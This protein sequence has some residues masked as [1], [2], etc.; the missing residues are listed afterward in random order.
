V[1]VKLG[2]LNSG[3]WVV[4]NVV[5]I[6]D[7]PLK[8]EQLV[9]NTAQHD[10]VECT[11]G[12]EQDPGSA[13]VADVD[14]MVRKLAGFSIKVFKPTKDKITRAGPVSAQAEAGNIFIV[15]AAWN[16]A[17]LTSLENFPPEN[18][19]GH[20][21]DVDALSGAFNSLAQGYSILDVL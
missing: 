3:N 7:T 2:K 21:D 12:L 1:G 14:N 10:G 6:R 17:F 20:D 4:L 18:Q 19:V 13:G 5:R 16:D 11:V 8:V 15:R 9:L